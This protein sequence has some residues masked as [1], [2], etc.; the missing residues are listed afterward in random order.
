[1]TLFD[2][3]PRTRWLLTL[4]AF[5]VACGQP[6]AT[7]DATAMNDASDTD[8]AVI[9]DATS[10]DDASSLPDT[11]SSA[12][13]A[14]TNDATSADAASA[15]DATAEAS[16]GAYPAG[17]Y[18]SNQGDT[19]EDLQL[20]GYVNTAGT[21]LSTMVPFGAVSMQSLRQTG[22]RYALVHTSA[23]Y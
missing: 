19:L 14:N 6:M 16:V 3:S 22:R 2:H 9:A 21:Q 8:R 18:G 11:S 5:G 13:A 7:P 23:T 10:G 1:M 20:D 12:D 15:P 17:P 4:S